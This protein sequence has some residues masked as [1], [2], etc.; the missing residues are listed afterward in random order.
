MLLA[1]K[2]RKMYL[3]FAKGDEETGNVTLCV[4]DGKK[5]EEIV[6][7]L[8]GGDID[9]IISACQRAAQKF[10]EKGGDRRNGEES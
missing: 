3:N 2:K 5:S 4:T 8:S 7:R 1:L 6:L 10:Q 9:Q